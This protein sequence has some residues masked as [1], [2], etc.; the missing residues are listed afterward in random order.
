MIKLIL[1]VLLYGLFPHSVS[2]ETN[3]IEIDNRGY[4]VNPSFEQDEGEYYVIFY[5][6]APNLAS[7]AAKSPG[8]AYISLFAKHDISKNVCSPP[9]GFGQYPHPDAPFLAMF[10][11][12]NANGFKNEELSEIIPVREL[13]VR[14]THEAYL[15][16]QRIVTKWRTQPYQL[17]ISD[18]ISF[19]EE[20]AKTT[21]WLNV[22]QRNLLNLPYSYLTELINANIES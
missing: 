14:I 20:V 15:N 11:E 4:C 8:H 22:P 3:R 19:V 16:I 1:L 18:C 10:K 12:G 6:T 2:A 17:G 13:Q 7:Q 9:A 21:P 5:A